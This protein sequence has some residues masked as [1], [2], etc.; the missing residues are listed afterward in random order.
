MEVIFAGGLMFAVFFIV[1]FCAALLAWFQGLLLT[2]RANVLL[3]IICLCLGV[4]F[5]LIGLLYWIFDFDA[6]EALMRAI[7]S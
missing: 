3:G 5:I 7:R 4:P 1:L 2:F 6:P